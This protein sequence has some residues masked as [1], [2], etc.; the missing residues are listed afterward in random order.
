MPT[1]TTEAPN[2]ERIL[3]RLD[4]TVIRRLDGLLQG[5]Y[6]SLFYGQ[7]LDLAEVREYQPSDDVR[8][9]D[10]NVTAR[11]GEPYVRQYLEDREITAWLLLDLSASVDL[12]NL[13]A[14][15]REMVLDFAGSL[16]R[17]LTRRGNRVGAILFSGNVDE[18]IPAGGGRRQALMLIH[19]LTRPDRKHTTGATDLGAVLDRAA[20]SIRRRSLVFVVSDFFAP[21][22]WEHPLRRLANRH[23]V[24]AVWMRDPS[25]EDLPDLGPMVHDGQVMHRTGDMVRDSVAVD[26][27]PAE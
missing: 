15:K 4:W 19:Q 10:W 18:V 26:I 16:A 20:Q 2:A 13:H 23:E 8:Y 14:R 5:D 12:H 11:M 22:G 25:E 6:R 1:P 27:N 9:M 21:P 17:L 24:L 3:N 7:G